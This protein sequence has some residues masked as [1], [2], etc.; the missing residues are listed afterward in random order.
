M[1]LSMSRTGDEIRVRCA[2]NGY[3]RL[4]GQ[5]THRREW[6]FSPRE[7]SI[8]DRLEGRFASAISYLHLHPEIRVVGEESDLE[9]PNGSR[10]RYSVRNGNLSAI[11]YSYHP[12]FGLSIPAQALK[13][14]I[15]GTP[16]AVLLT[17]GSN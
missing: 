7:F 3:R 13:V 4:P 16:C 11:A 8:E 14:A 2:H 5:V 15:A 17:P 6:Y 9:C 10:V 1:D 12:E